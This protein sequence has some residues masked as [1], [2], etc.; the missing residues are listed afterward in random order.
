MTR[1][2]CDDNLADDDLPVADEGKIWLRRAMWMI[3]GLFVFRLI[4]AAIVPVDLVHD[5]AYYWDWSR[6]LD[7][8]YYSKPPMIA[9]L[10]ALSTSLGGSSTFMVRLPAVVLSTAGLVLMYALGTRMYGAKAGF[11]AVL[12]SAAT[13]GNAA[14][15]L[16]MTIDAPLLFCWC[17]ALYC[18]WRFLERRS[19][20]KLWLILGMVA[21]GLGVLSKQTMLGFLPLAGIFLLASA[22]DRRELLRRGFWIWAVGSLLFLSPVLW[23][24]TQHGWI[25]AQHTGSHFA[26]QSVDLLKRLSRFGEF[27]AAQLGVVSPVTAALFAA[28]GVVAFRAF[29]KLGRRERFLLCF[30]GLPM[31]GVLCLSCVQRVQ[32][33]WPAAFYPAGVI[34][35]VGWALE[36]AEGLSLLRAGERKLRRAA[37][38]G[39]AFAVVAYVLPFGL[40]LEGTKLDPAVRLRGWERLGREVGGKFAAMPNPNET[41]VLVATGRTATS[42]LAFYMPQQPRVYLWNS[43]GDIRSQYDVW[44]G[45][46]G[47]HGW[48]AMIVTHADA[49]PP[50]DVYDA[51]EAVTPSAEVC[52]PVGSGRT[53]AYRLW[54]GVDFLGR[55]EP[56]RIASQAAEERTIR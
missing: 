4:Y 31:A 9:W 26:G 42:E 14:L 53:H 54:R 1:P 18:F 28:V 13:P 34:L 11:W 29:P 17:A 43:A 39:A 33:N 24:N 2:N 15:G 21:T 30:S 51:F 45:P 41:F 50:A 19:D 12:L 37:V 22:E 44:G 3:G 49:Q 6:Q 16:L 52:V 55:P 20:R 7:W 46:V 56:A 38:V 5:E 48:D 40:G 35:L 25:T 23:W 27:L 8:G 36:R 10:I 32:P 47:K